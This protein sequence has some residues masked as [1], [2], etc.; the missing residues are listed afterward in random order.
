M[1]EPLRRLPV[2]SD[3]GEEIGHFVAIGPDEITELALH[4]EVGA[5][6]A[7]SGFTLAPVF[8]GQGNLISVSVVSMTGGP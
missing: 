6:L 4:S 8:D 5:E 2:L 7:A 3:H 1:A